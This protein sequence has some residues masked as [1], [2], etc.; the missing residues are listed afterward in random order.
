MIL[1]IDLGNSYARCVRYYNTPQWNPHF[2]PIT[3]LGTASKVYFANAQDEN[4][5]VG[6]PA[7]LPGKIKPN[8]Y[9]KAFK[10]G[11]DDNAVIEREGGFKITPVELSALVLKKLLATTEAE[12]GPNTWVPKGIVVSVPAYFNEKQNRNTIDAIKL[13]MDK[14]FNGRKGYNEDIFL[15]LI[16]EP[17]AIA[18]DLSYKYPGWFDKAKIFVFDL[19]SSH[20]EISIVEISNPNKESFSFNTIQTTSAHNISGDIF[21]DLLSAYVLEESG[22]KES[23][24]SMPG[25]ALFNERC[26]ELKCALTFAE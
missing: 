6:T 17:V 14:Q 24:L 10:R 2:K 15:R 5:I 18:M 26:T 22:Y 8:L 13:A 16:P 19:G 9:F 4:P 7:I 1:G 11:M 12:E 25:K 20:L 3:Y 21:D 23:E